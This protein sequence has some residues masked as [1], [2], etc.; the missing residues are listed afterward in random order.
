M[1]GSFP[2][3]RVTLRPA[4]LAAG[5]TAQLRVDIQRIAVVVDA[6]D[7]CTV[8]QGGLT[9]TVSASDTSPLG[10]VLVALPGA[11]VTATLAAVDDDPDLANN[12]WRATL[13]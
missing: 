6:D 5:S 13:G 4:G 3:Y 7:R 10:L 9:C 12:T 8:R 2:L 1:S 11:T